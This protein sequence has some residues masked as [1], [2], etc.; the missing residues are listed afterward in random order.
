MKIV[1]WRLF[2]PAGAWPAL[3][4]AA[5]VAG[6]ALVANP[7]SLIERSFASAISGPAAT[8]LADANGYSAVSGSEDFWLSRNAE[9]RPANVKAVAWTAPVTA[10][11]RIIISR[12]GDSRQVLDV[13]AVEPLDTITTRIDTSP[14]GT[15]QFV[16]TCRDALAPDAELIKLTVDATGHGLTRIKG[17][18]RAL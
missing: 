3:S 16:L 15:G 13:V 12:G 17:G 1:S 7:D 8:T 18:P 9:Q 5:L 6:G 11:E 4:A 14:A 10:G 2:S